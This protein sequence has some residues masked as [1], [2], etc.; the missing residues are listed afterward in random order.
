MPDDLKAARDVSLLVPDD[1]IAV[2]DQLA[3]ALERPRDWVMLRALRCYLEEEG[4]E[5]LEDSESLAE[6]D[7]GEAISCDDLHEKLQV[8]IDRAE[9]ARAQD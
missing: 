9:K 1:V 5:I 6:L 7:R 2:Y 3:A 8:I 4:A